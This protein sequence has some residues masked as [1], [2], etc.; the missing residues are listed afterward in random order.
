MQL[1]LFI[2]ALLSTSCA[3]KFESLVRQGGPG[4]EKQNPV[5]H[6]PSVELAKYH[7]FFTVEVPKDSEYKYELR[8]A[9]G[10]VINDRKLCPR[11]VLG[12]NKTIHTF[13]ANYGISPGRFN[14]DGD[15]IDL[16]VLG[17]DEKYQ[18]MV[19]DNEVNPQVVRI[20]GLMKM[21]ECTQ[22]PCRR[23]REWFRDWKIL[24]VDAADPS[25][26]NIHQ[27]KE[28]PKRKLDELAE[29]WS[30]YKGPK[31]GKDGVLYPQ[32]RVTGFMDRNHATKF[33]KQF[34]VVDRQKE[35]LSCAKLFQQVL[36][37][38]NTL[39]HFDYPKPDKKYLNCLNQLW[40]PPFFM[41]KFTN[42]FFMNYSAYQFIRIKLKQ[43]VKFDHA[44]SHM[45]QLKN[46][47]GTHYRFVSYD[48]PSPGTGNAIFEWVKT[49]NRNK[50]CPAGT[51]E[52]HYS[53]RPLLD[54]EY[55]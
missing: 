50:G 39:A 7:I 47:N 1:T 31:M 53:K 25:Y 33:L 30:N 42:D 34:K 8:T 46:T 18:D 14:Y 12:S 36:E 11:K 3:N 49:K 40:F 52:Q 38:Q 43:K 17:E 44:L 35:V 21:E 55:E 28:V 27:L 6:I 37:D 54:F 48:E 4:G 13:P 23:E 26:R 2:I 5:F 20:I 15:P 45:Q 16:V 51:P 32:T 9:T 24:A 29:Y 19:E 10:Q 22:L 41:S